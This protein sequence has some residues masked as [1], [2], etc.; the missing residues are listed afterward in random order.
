MD[1]DQVQAEV[2]AQV[3]ADA[4][5]MARVARHVDRHPDAYPFVLQLAG[6]VLRVGME[7]VSMGE[8]AEANL[9]E[10]L[11]DYGQELLQEDDPASLVAWTGDPFT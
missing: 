3:D 6:T 4:D 10:G 1:N 8:G 9:I 2:D 5:L 11:Y 7:A